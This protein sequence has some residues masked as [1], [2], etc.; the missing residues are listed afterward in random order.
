MMEAGSLHEILAA[1]AESAGIH[2]VADA[3]RSEQSSLPSLLMG[4][5]RSLYET[6]S[7]YVAPY[8][9]WRREGEFFRVRRHR[10]Y[11]LRQR[12]IPDRIVRQWAARLRKA[13]RLT[14]EDA[15]TVALS[16]RDEQLTQFEEAMGEAGVLLDLGFE[17]E[18]P[19]AARKRSVL[20]AY[21][22]LLERQRRLLDAGGSVSIAAMPPEARRWLQIALTSGGHAATAGSQGQIL[23]IAGSDPAAGHPLARGTAG[24]VGRRQIRSVD[25]LPHRDESHGRVPHPA[26][27]RH[28][29]GTGESGRRLTVVDGLA[30]AAWGRACSW[31]RF[32]DFHSGWPG[33]SPSSSARSRANSPPRRRRLG[34]DRGGAAGSGRDR[35]SRRVTSQSPQIARISGTGPGLIRSCR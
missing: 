26:A 33:P 15:A 35:M 10:W 6:L 9:G 23:R 19:V 2:L 28:A 8:G 32:S 34:R 11:H 20:R 22:S 4:E 25:P 21:G 24:G 18:G 12:E 27:S 17:E 1:V 7:R 3:Y 14:L 16:L 5:E 30:P 29:G 13:D 31:A